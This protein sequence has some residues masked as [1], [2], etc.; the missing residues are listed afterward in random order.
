MNR[1][2]GSDTCIGGGGLIHVS[3]GGPIHVHPEHLFFCIYE[4]SRNPGS[5]ASGDVLEVRRH[6]WGGFGAT[7]LALYKRSQKPDFFVAHESDPPSDTGIRPPHPIQVSD[8][9]LRFMCRHDIRFSLI[10]GKISDF[11]HR[12]RRGGGV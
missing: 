5:E 6:L 8:P 10:F 9:P 3:E 2:G 7:R 1:R 11:H 4:K 12:N